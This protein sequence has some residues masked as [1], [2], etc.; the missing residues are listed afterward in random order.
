M[1]IPKAEQ[2]LF[3][4]YAKLHHPAF[5]VDVVL[6][7]IKYIVEKMADPGLTDSYNDA[8][9]VVNSLR[10]DQT[11]FQ[12]Y[13]SGQ[14]AIGERVNA[15]LQLERLLSP[16]RAKKLSVLFEQ[17][18]NFMPMPVEMSAFQ[19]FKD[20]VIILV[21]P[22]PAAAKPSVMLTLDMHMDHPHPGVYY[23][24]DEKGSRCVVL[25][26]SAETPAG[27]PLVFTASCDNAGKM[28]SVLRAKHNAENRWIEVDPGWSL[29]GMVHA[30]CQS[31]ESVLQKYND[32]NPTPT[33]WTCE[34]VRLE[35]L[36]RYIFDNETCLPEQIGAY[37]AVGDDQSYIS[38]QF[39]GMR[40][41]YMNTKGEYPSRHNVIALADSTILFTIDFDQ[42]P[43]SSKIEYVHTANAVLNELAMHVAMGGKPLP[44]LIRHDFTI[45]PTQPNTGTTE[46]ESPP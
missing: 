45:H 27:V 42:L 5:E 38:F 41:S 36:A 3:E 7:N 26:L 15:Q 16:A 19:K 14:G 21:S 35:T 1:L 44:C 20:A 22:G 39:N 4:S 40:V 32:E 34:W 2:R 25:I 43:E 24:R 18:F 28:H 13:F 29:P 37:C 30:L 9:R 31:L 10:G 6:K 33:D 46:K 8:I 11:A 17:Y 12:K 23:H